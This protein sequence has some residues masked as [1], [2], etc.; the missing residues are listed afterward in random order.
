MA[1]SHDQGPL[2]TTKIDNNRNVLSIAV[3]LKNF[4]IFFYGQQNF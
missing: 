1:Q 3:G 4:C 2:E